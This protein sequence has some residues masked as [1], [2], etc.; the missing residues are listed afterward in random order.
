MK[1]SAVRAVM[2]IGLFQIG[3]L[4]VRFLSDSHY[5]VL[6]GSDSHR[7]YETWSPKENF[8]GNWQAE[9]P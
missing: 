5:V 9:H 1:N 7:S 2:N 8:H 4:F 6:S 3:P